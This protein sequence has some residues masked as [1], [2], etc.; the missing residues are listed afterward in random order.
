MKQIHNVIENHTFKLHEVEESSSHIYD[1]N[2]QSTE[3]VDINDIDHM[4]LL[5]NE[6]SINSE[7]PCD[8][9]ISN[10]NFQVS[11][12]SSDRILF[13][14]ICHPLLYQIPRRIY[15]N[16]KDCF[17]YIGISLSDYLKVDPLS[18]DNTPIIYCNG[19]III[20]FDDIN[21]IITATHLWIFN[22]DNSCV[23][24][25][26]ENIVTSTYCNK[27]F[28]YN[29]CSSDSDFSNPTRESSSLSN[30]CNILCYEC[31]IRNSDIY[32]DTENNNENKQYSNMTRY[33]NMT[34]T[35]EKQPTSL[36]NDKIDYDNIKSIKSINE[37]IQYT[38]GCIICERVF[39][40]E[41]NINSHLNRFNQKD[42][43]KYIKK[44]FAA[45]CLYVILEK[46]CEKIHNYLTQI[47][48]EFFQGLRHGVKYNKW[49]L[50]P[51]RFTFSSFSKKMCLKRDVDTLEKNITSLQNCL[52]KIQSQI[53]KSYQKKKKV[54]L[55]SDE[56]EEIILHYI[57]KF[58]G[59]TI[60]LSRVKSSINVNE[61]LSNLYLN[62]KRNEYMYTALRI[63]LITLACSIASVITGL[64]GMNL[65]TGL[66]QDPIAWY[67]VA[68]GIIIP[69]ML[70]GVAGWFTGTLCKHDITD[71]SIQME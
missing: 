5:N 23:I 41:N 50:Y 40:I 29:D 4:G 30:I 27:T 53:E 8:H 37:K 11:C 63:S 70:W 28:I 2:L 54:V 56:W 47:K 19:Y 26:C 42:E 45:I 17:M 49:Y 36:G 51:W 25:I 20:K 24:S 21:A 67:I 62:F 46:C 12:T 9:S 55:S 38:I 71:I 15:Y 16:R 7:I 35:K 68:F 18:S 61:Q 32:I 13:Y 31:K 60:Q 57:I 3:Y 69:I 59:Y 33:G 1:S 44:S 43:S 14:V 65:L 10:D 34:N 52:K 22:P 58:N 64:F 6:F 48:S 39:L 66:E